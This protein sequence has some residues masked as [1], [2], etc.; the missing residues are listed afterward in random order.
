[1]RPRSAVLMPALVTS[2]AFLRLP[3]IGGPLS[4][5][6]LEATC[7]LSL[8]S[9]CHHKSTGDVLG[10]IESFV[11]GADALAEH[12]ASA[13]WRQRLVFDRSVR[14]RGLLRC[15]SRRNR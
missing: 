14:A 3:R 12:Q 5:L 13:R 9:P 4:Q 15:V 10:D 2:A 7:R 6:D 1:M 11:F 8:L